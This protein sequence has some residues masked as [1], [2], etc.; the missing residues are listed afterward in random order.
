MAADKGG[1]LREL[2][3]VARDPE[4]EL[5]LLPG[6]ERHRPDE[7][8]RQALISALRSRLMEAHRPDLQAYLKPQVDHAFAS[9]AQQKV[10]AYF[11]ATGAT[12]KELFIPG[13]MVASVRTAEHG[14][15]LDDYVSHAIREYGAQPLFGDK[16]FIRFERESTKA[17]EGESIVATTI[18]Y[19]TP[20]PGSR[21]RR[22]L[23]LVATLARPSE[24]AST[25]IRF[26]GWRTALDLCVSTLKWT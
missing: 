8:D 17:L 15:R 1:S 25:D 7:A 12:D 16:R 10:V 24:M 18:V 3:G 6:W 9:M 20:I 2:L 11:A 22:A 26:V 13:S 4:F 21:R 19:L 5:K 23:Q 14:A